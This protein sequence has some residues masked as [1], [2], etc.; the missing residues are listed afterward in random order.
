MRAAKRCGMHKSLYCSERDGFIGGISCCSN[1]L[2]AVIASCKHHRLHRDP[3]VQ[4][5]CVISSSQLPN[6]IE[7]PGIALWIQFCARCQPWPVLSQRFL[8]VP[9]P[10]G[11]D[12]SSSF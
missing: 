4:G 11:A 1:E 7:V 10:L 2:T 3:T 8:P 12:Y 5:R 9:C 6:L